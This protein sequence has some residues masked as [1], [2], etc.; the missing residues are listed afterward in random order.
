MSRFFGRDGIINQVIGYSTES[1][2]RQN[3]RVA[4]ILCMQIRTELPSRSLNALEILRSQGKNSYFSASTGQAQSVVPPTDF[5]HNAT[6]ARGVRER[7]RRATAIRVC[8][9]I[10]MGMSVR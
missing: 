10:E 2:P 8:L 4:S 7:V 6:S 3:Q 9:G 5:H 1:I